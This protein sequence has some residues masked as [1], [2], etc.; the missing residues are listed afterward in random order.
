[1]LQHYHAAHGSDPAI[2]TRVRE[3]LLYDAASDA[4]EETKRQQD[5]EAALLAQKRMQEE[6]EAAK[7]KAA[8]DEAAAEAAQQLKEAQEAAAAASKEEAEALEAP[9]RR[10]RVLE[11]R[12][13]RR[14][15]GCR[16]DEG[17]G[18][19]SDREDELMR[20]RRIKRRN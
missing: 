14:G 11:A 17:V 2:G 7:A 20:W 3:P 5:K 12:G 16:W 19:A 4:R 15:R 6:A 8:V 13:G 9:R 10:H 18:G 1:M